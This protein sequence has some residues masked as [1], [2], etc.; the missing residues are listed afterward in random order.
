MLPERHILHKQSYG[1]DAMAEQDGDTH[2]DSKKLCLGK[3]KPKVLVCTV[4]LLICLSNFITMISAPGDELP[5][6]QCA[7]EPIFDEF[8]DGNS[9]VLN[10]TAL[11]TTF[12]MK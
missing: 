11:Q 4:L 3:C 10:P 2:S 6:P 7:P 12:M 1:G 5:D 8:L 9:L